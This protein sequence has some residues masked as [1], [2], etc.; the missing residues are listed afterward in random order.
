MMKIHFLGGACE[1]GMNMFLYESDSSAVIVDC[2]VRFGDFNT[3]GVDYIIPDFSYL[4]DIKDKLAGLVVTHGHEDH[5]GGVP[6]L[7][8]NIKLDVYGGKLAVGI[9]K[10]KMAEHMLKCSYHKINDGDMIQLG[11]IDISFMEVNHS[12]PDTFCLKIKNRDNVFFHM[13]DFKID[14]TPAGG[15]PYKNGSFKRFVGK[16]KITAL[17]ID[18][19]SAVNE[20][21]CPSEISVRDGL[22]ETIKNAKGRVFFTTFSSNIYRIS[23]IVDICNILNRKI[24]VEGRSI[25]KN[26]KIARDLNLVSFQRDIFINLRDSVSYPDNELCYLITGC[27]GEVNSALN[28]VVT[29][30]RVSLQIRKGDTFVFS[31]RVIPGNEREYI[32]ILNNIVYNGGRFVDGDTLHIHTSGHA[33]KKDIQMVLKQVSPGYFIPI[34]GE[35]IHSMANIQNA[36]GKGFDE[37]KCIFVEN[38]VVLTF[39]NDELVDKT[40]NPH[41]KK[42]ID[43]RGGF[44][45]DEDMVKV[46]KKLSRDGVVFALAELNVE[47]LT[48]SFVKLVSVGFDIKYDFRIFLKN[49]IEKELQGF[50]ENVAYDR[51]EFK[52]L[53]EKYIARLLKKNLDRR[54]EIVVEFILS[55][56]D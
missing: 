15:K 25:Q 27:Q 30:E 29:K 13:S 42:Y 8:K 49:K 6:Y 19:T 54:P 3:P 44:E 34:H 5:L 18:S 33:Y 50:Y 41:T 10:N 37:E 28:R 51:Y 4:H 12:I 20:G 36:V 56:G 55:K 38:G 40:V 22:F 1:I 14:K 46:R 43:A 11:D 52:V 16:D 35:A 23:Q 24:V 31:S 48:A 39:E 9:L 53:L 26:L 45:I 47:N 32:N 2:G 7:L 21:K 17:L